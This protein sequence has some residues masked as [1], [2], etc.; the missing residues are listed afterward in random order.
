[1]NSYSA[2]SVQF[3]TSL[4]SGLPIIAG[5]AALVAILMFTVRYYLSPDP[6]PQKRVT[7]TK[8]FSQ[9]CGAF[10][11]IAVFMGTSFGTKVFENF[12]GGETGTNKDIANNASSSLDVNG[13]QYAPV[14]KKR[15]KWWET[16][17]NSQSMSDIDTS[18]NAGDVAQ[19][20]IDV[21]TNQGEYAGYAD[22]YDSLKELTGNAD[23]SE[24]IGKTDSNGSKPTAGPVI[25]N[26][27][28]SE[29]DKQN[30][31][32]SGIQDWL[33]QTEENR[34]NLANSDKLLPNY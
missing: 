20:I 9:V 31:N 32:N 30:F 29:E 2:S 15:E 1:M 3:L 7:W 26:G 16:R 14:V 6:E 17:N 4:T 11:I 33:K 25:N 28:I 18:Q 34:K 5:S 27:N 24:W 10:L 23:F 21:K 13:T 19:D 22:M 8:K 12:T